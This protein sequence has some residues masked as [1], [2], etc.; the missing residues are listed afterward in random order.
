M[1][2][3]K[4]RGEQAPPPKDTDTIQMRNPKREE[5]KGGYGWVHENRLAGASGDDAQRCQ[6][7]SP[8][9]VPPKGA[10]QKLCRVNN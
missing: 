4:A 3:G 8:F 7:H 10:R 6:T 2:A 9:V 5:T 1:A